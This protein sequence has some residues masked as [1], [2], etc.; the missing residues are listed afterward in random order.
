MPLTVWIALSVFI[1]VCLVGDLLLGR[2]KDEPM[3]MRAAGMWSLFWT[4]LGL[5][6]AG[7][8]LVLDDSKAASEY[9]AG[10]IIEKSLSLDNLFV[11]AMLIGFFAVPPIA[12]RKVLIYGIAG[13]I[14]LRGIFIFAGAAALEQFH[15]A[16]YVMGAFLVLTGIKMARHDNSEI[17]PEKT[18]ALRAFRKLVPSTPVYHGTKLFVR[19]NGKRLATPLVAALVMV[20]AF[21]VLFAIDSVPAIF[22]VSRDTFV[23]FSA[24][25]FSLLGMTSLFVL[26]AGMLDR[27]HYLNYGL[28]A[29]LVFVGA[30]M[31]L[32]DVIHPPIWVSLLVI[33]AC[34]TLAI[35]ASQKFPKREHTH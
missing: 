4:L 28:S 29:I 2:K 19:E 20:A 10:F 18:L 15:W 6:F 14:V 8:I 35:V 30:K 23:V 32:S 31:L 3:S 13:A 7:V 16:I 34:I 12:Q 11:F 21:D 33:T 22:A 26:L 24:N 9:V 5:G 25:A 17:D 1:V 27:F